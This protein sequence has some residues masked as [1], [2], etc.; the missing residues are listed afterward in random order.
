MAIAHNLLGAAVSVL[1]LACAAASAD[2]PPV[3]GSH[4][5]LVRFN[6]LNLDQ[7][8]D[9]AR[10]FNRVSSAADKVCGTRS[11]A[12]HY[13]KIADYEI[14]YKDTVAS[15]VARIDRPSLT[16]YFQ[17]RSSDLASFSNNVT[18]PQQ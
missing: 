7:P 8:R 5:E 12:A 15:A 16:A 18:L 6:D 2:T 3:I 1:S 17:Q 13:K 14:C 10:L 11:F 9:V 4:F